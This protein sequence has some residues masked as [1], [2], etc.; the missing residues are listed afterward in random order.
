MVGAT[1]L[2]MLPKPHPVSDGANNESGDRRK[3]IGITMAAAP[4]KAIFLPPL[5]HAGV[6]HHGACSVSLMARD[7]S[8]RTQRG[9]CYLNGPLRSGIRLPVSNQLPHLRI[10]GALTRSA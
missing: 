4:S 3:A 6:K 8:G 10:A 1:M 2:R 5:L 7:G 9:S